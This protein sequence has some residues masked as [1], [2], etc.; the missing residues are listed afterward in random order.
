MSAT[1]MGATFLLPIPKNQKVL[2]LA[3]ADHA[4][5]DGDHIWP[6]NHL[7]VRKTSDTPRNVTRLLRQLEDGGWIKNVHARRPAGPGRGHHV[8]GVAV[9]WSIDS[10]L[11]YET[12]R[13]HGWTQ[14][15]KTPR[16]AFSKT[17]DTTRENHGPGGRKTRPVVSTQPSGRNINNRADYENPD[18]D[19]EPIATLMASGLKASEVFN[20]IKGSPTGTASG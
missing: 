11:V 9:E 10:E 7:L 2:L 17:E 13:A 14:K 3:L 8:P 15:T 19:L 20:E 1:L 18:L 6:G 16:S 4:S 12:A 5:D